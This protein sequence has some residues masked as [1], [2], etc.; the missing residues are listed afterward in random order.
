MPHLNSGA[1]AK[2]F[3]AM[4]GKDEL[5]QDTTLAISRALLTGYAL[6]TWHTEWPVHL[7]YLEEDV[8][9]VHDTPGSRATV[10]GIPIPPHVSPGVEVQMSTLLRC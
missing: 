2:A 8:M 9:E 4:P 10:E 6:Y 7:V 1:P 3:I 5:T